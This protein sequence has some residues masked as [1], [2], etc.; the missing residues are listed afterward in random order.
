[1][2]ESVARLTLAQVMIS[3]FMSSGPMSGSVLT[4]PSLDPALYSVSPSHSDPPLLMLALMR[5]L[6][7]SQD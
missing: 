1:M 7:L 2:A 3:W 6:S 5:S 4:A